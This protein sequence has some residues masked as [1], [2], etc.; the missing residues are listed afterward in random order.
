MSLISAQNLLERMKS[1]LG[2][3]K[4]HNS[5]KSAIE[6][7]RL[8]SEHGYRFSDEELSVALDMLMSEM[9]AKPYSKSA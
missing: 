3:M 9:L 4:I 2:F 7:E 5:A 8:I 6:R 1:D